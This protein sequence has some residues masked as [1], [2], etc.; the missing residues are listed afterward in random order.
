MKKLLFLSVVLFVLCGCSNDDKL[1]PDSR[2]TN[3][4]FLYRIFTERRDWR[5]QLRKLVEWRMH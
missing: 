5:I 2:M 3:L 1:K 4:L